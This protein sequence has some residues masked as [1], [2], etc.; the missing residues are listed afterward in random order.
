MSLR[1]YRRV[2]ELNF[3]QIKLSC[4]YSMFVE[5]FGEN[6]LIEQFDEKELMVHF[7]NDRICVVTLRVGLLISILL[8]INKKN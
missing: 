6:G 8:E 1:V 7:S 2:R 4:S 3:H 5:K